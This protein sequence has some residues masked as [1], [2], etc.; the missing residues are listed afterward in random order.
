MFKA[1]MSNSSIFVDSITTIGEL[2]DEGVFKIN[3]NG[4]TLIAADR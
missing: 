4:M 1:L 3:K 2:I